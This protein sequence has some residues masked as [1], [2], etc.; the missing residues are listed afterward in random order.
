MRYLITG[1]ALLR[2][3]YELQLGIL[4][5]VHGECEAPCGGPPRRPRRQLADAESIAQKVVA[6][7]DSEL[8]KEIAK[9]RA[10]LA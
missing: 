5:C 6:S 3:V 7:S 2:D 1:E 4:F 8:G 9:L 10:A